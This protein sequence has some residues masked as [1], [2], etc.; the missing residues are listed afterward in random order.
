LGNAFLAIDSSQFYLPL[1][2]EQTVPLRE[3]MITLVSAKGM[4]AS[5]RRFANP[6]KANRLWKPERES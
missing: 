6:D 5:G 1:L 2:W 4:S 3:T